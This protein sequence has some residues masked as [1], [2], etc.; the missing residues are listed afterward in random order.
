M[1]ELVK[2]ENCLELASIYYCE[3][4]HLYLYKEKQDALMKDGW[5][6]HSSANL[7]TAS[8]EKLLI[9]VHGFLPK[10]LPPKQNFL[11]VDIQPEIVT[12]PFMAVFPIQII[13]EDKIGWIKVHNLMSFKRV[14]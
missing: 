7:S 10:I 2:S 8:F 12:N 6:G 11:V 13:T 1:D 9:N 3:D 4:Y 14:V 5:C